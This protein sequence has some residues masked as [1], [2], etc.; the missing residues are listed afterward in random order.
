M[1]DTLFM[2]TVQ[3]ISLITWLWR[4]GEPEFLSPMALIIREIVLGRLPQLALHRQQIETHPS[5][6]MKE[7][8]LLVQ[9]P[10]P[11]GQASGLTQI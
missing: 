4:P 2:A 10:W 3:G 1:S 8:Y 7:A 11:E 5:N 6:S 9:V